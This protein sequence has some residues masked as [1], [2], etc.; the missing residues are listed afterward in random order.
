[1]TDGAFIVVEGLDASGKH[2]QAVR[3]ADRIREHGRDVKQVEFPAYDTPFG[4][5]VKDY[6]DGAYGDREDVPF[7]VRSLLYAADRYQF[8]DE[9]DRFLGD[10]GVIVADRF[11]QSNYAFQTAG[12]DE[13]DARDRL[14]WMKEVE[15]RLPEP[16]LVIFLDVPPRITAGLM[17]ERD[18][19][20]HES[21]RDFQR[22]VYER[23][24]ALAEEEG[25]TVI[26][27]VD[28]GNLR[29]REEIQADIW[30][31]VA[32]VL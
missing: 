11:N 9:F 2:T 21:D 20:Q 32:S 3:L 28:D 15:S 5:L 31:H 8:R 27:C 6:L 22:Q 16:D 30:E 13:A 14:T 25:W 17:A 7:E 10:G 19:D 4:R 23:Y 24:M 26:D 18:Q 29:P 12:A 1:M